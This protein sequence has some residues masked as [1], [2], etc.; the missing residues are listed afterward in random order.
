M[1][2]AFPLWLLL[3]VNTASHVG[4]NECCSASLL[5]IISAFFIDCTAQKQE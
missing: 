4:Q 2:N 3:P 5:L 1:P